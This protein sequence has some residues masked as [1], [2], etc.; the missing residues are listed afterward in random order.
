MTGLMRN[1]N[2]VLTFGSISFGD[3]RDGHP[4]MRSW[5]MEECYVSWIVDRLVLDFLTDPH[6]TNS[7]PNVLLRPFADQRLV[8][9]M[10]FFGFPLEISWG[11][12]F[13]DFSDGLY[14]EPNRTWAEGLALDM[15]PK[16][17]GPLSDLAHVDWWP[18]QTVWARS[19]AQLPRS[20]MD[21]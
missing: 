3:L 10:D 1:K 15:I 13:L 4:I 8:W 5:N 12:Q 19:K 14:S 7:S 18:D 6:E 17:A 9:L 20:S 21:S 2:L 16:G 11:S